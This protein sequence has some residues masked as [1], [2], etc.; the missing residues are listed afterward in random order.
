MSSETVETESACLHCEISD[1]DLVTCEYCGLDCSCPLHGCTSSDCG[2]MLYWWSD[3]K[4]C[5][6][7]S[8]IRQHI[9]QHYD[10][11]GLTEPGES[12]EDVLSGFQECCDGP[13]PLTLEDVQAYIDAITGEG[14]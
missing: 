7:C 12:A 13:C 14:K 11:S 9:E 5:A 2:G 10:P 8:T 3:Q 6:C 1:D 4:Y